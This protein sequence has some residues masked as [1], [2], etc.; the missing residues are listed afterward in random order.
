MEALI[1]AL[2]RDPAVTRRRRL[3]VGAIAAAVVASALFTWQTAARRRAETERAIAQQIDDATRAT[4]DARAKAGGATALRQRAFDAFDAG[5]RRTGETLWRQART[6]LPVVDADF[7]RAERSLETAFALD[8]ARAQHRAALADLRVEHLLFAED[9]RLAAKVGVLEERLAAVDGD[10]SRRKALAAPGTLL[11]HATPGAARVLLERYDRDPV[12]GRRREVPLG[13]L[14]SP[15]S[16]KSLPPGSYRLVIEGDGRARV[17]YPFELRRAERRVVD[18][19]L[20][21]ASAIPR[22]FIPVAP[23]TFWY[24]DADEQLRTQFLDAAPIHRRTT[25]AYLIARHETTVQDWIAFLDDLPAA[26]RARRTPA[27]KGTFRGAVAL[28][29]GAD[30]WRIVIQPA[31][32]RYQAKLHEPIAYEGRSRR[33]RQDW[34]RF[35]ISG[36]SVDDVAHYLAWLRTSGRVPGARL[37]SELEW[38]RAARGADDRLFPHGDELSDDDANIDL[39]YGKVDGAFGPDEVG[40]HPASRSPFDVDDLAGN[41]MEM[42]ASDHLP[43]GVVIRGGGYFFSPASARSTNHEQVPQSFRDVAIGLRVCADAAD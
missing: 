10:G 29:H 5:D 3:G 14:A 23:G 18:L 32:R 2:E 4:T 13:A 24:G 38:E 9:F 17:V 35:P 22:G 11:L 40:E 6:L 37:C 36:V 1:E 15:S 7:D 30:G 43:G 25:K 34:L 39:T 26:E 42:V 33:Q 41:V 19:A 27:V 8:A 12:T 16:E 31:S 21:A 20:P 28:A